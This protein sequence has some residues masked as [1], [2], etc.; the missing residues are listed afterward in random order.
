MGGVHPLVLIVQHDS[1][2][3]HLA[4]LKNI[5][6]IA[7][8][9]VTENLGKRYKRTLLESWHLLH[10]YTTRRANMTAV[11]TSACLYFTRA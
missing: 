1:L 3:I 2:M 11:Y 6:V 5:Y 7:L 9:K 10:H 4:D 8:L